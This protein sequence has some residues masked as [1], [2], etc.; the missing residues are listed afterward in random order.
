MLHIFSRAQ[1][2]CSQ[3]LTTDAHLVTYLEI[4]QSINKMILISL[5]VAKLSHTHS[6]SRIAGFLDSPFMINLCFLLWSVLILV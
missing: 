5:R 2:K 6:D 3:L 1:N 4:I